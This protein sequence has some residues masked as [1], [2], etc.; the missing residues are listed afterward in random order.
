[1]RHATSIHVRP[2]AW[3]GRS[4]E[5]RLRRWFAGEKRRA[6]ERQQTES[7]DLLFHY[8]SLNISHTPQRATS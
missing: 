4:S 1:M 6:K 7:H 8:G 3:R 2:R 5:C